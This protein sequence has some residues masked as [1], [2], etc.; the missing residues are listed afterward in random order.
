MSK[1]AQILLQLRNGAKVA[2]YV[3]DPHDSNPTAL[4]KDFLTA[5]PQFDDLLKPI[6]CQ[7]SNEFNG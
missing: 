2:I 7:P 6:L 3:V 5:Y 4:L 1:L